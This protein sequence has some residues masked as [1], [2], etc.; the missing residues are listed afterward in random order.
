MARILKKYFDYLEQVI[1]ANS[2]GSLGG[3]IVEPY[4][5]CKRFYFSAQKAG[6]KSWKNGR[7]Q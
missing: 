7:T 1:L 5:G 2:T 3:V 6:L 4:Q